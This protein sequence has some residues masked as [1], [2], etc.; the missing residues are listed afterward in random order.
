MTKTQTQVLPRYFSIELTYGYEAPR[1]MMFFITSFFLHMYCDYSS[2]IHMQQR[3]EYHTYTLKN[4]KEYC[5]YVTKNRSVQ[6]KLNKPTKSKV[7]NNK[8]K[9]KTKTKTD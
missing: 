9:T 8:K 2:L 4:L 7:G 1:N 3:L 5:I 6:T